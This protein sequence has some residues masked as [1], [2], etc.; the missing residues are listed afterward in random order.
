MNRQTTSL[1]GVEAELTAHHD[2]TRSLLMVSLRAEEAP[3]LPRTPMRVAIV[4]D[5]SGSMSGQKLV[6]ARQAAAQFVR[7]LSPDDRV[8]VVAYDNQVHVLGAPQPPNEALARSIEALEVGGSTALYEGWLVG[9]KAIGSGGRVILLSDGQANCGPYTT[10]DELSAHAGRTYQKYGVTTST[11]GVGADYDEA[12]MAGMARAGGGAHYFAHEADAIMDAFGMERFS[13]EAVVLH[14]V[15]VRYGNHTE[16]FGHFWGGET[17]RR[18]FRATDLGGLAATVRYT[19]RGD[20]QR[21]TES[22]VVPSEFGYSEDVRLEALLQ[23]ASAVEGDM[24]HVRD[25]RTATAMKDRLRQIVLALLAHPSS[26]EPGVQAMIARL[27]DSILRLERLERNYVESEATM[28][29]KRSSQS[30]HNLRE[31]AKAFTSFE[32]EREATLSTARLMAEAPGAPIEVSREAYELAPAADWARWHA[33]PI[34]ADESRIIVAMEDPRQGFVVA[35]IGQTVGRRVRAVYASKTPDEIQAMLAD[36][37][38]RFG[39]V[40]P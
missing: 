3:D 5:R 26:D 6:I 17:K 38:A 20:G 27:K 18:V 10:A 34:F 30:S 29:R 33:I 37:N 21:R 24:I 16:Q 12:L 22:L 8:S 15:S 35:E 39:G 28:H 14:R 23:E 32:D 36:A 7:S 9:A 13:A 11:I 19:W 4:L 1:P 31:R 40:G 25:P 2:E